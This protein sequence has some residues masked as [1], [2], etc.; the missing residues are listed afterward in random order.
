[1]APCDR[2][3]ASFKMEGVE[4]DSDGLARGRYDVEAMFIV[5]VVARVAI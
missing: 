4:S 2:V 3:A 5:W 1:M